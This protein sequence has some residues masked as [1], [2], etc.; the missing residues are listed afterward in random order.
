MD[1][2]VNQFDVYMVGR[3]EPISVFAIDYHQ[4][5]RWIVFTGHSGKTAAKIDESC[6]VGIVMIQS[7]TPS[8][9]GSAEYCSPKSP[10]LPPEFD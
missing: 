3:A 7:A 4:D 10:D 2:I 9:H 5:D 8:P 6:A 1:D